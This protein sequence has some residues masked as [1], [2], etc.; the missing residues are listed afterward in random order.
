M[1]VTD[2][3]VPVAALAD[4]FEFMRWYDDAKLHGF[5]VLITDDK[6][7]VSGNIYDPAMKHNGFSAVGSQEVALTA[8]TPQHIAGKITMPK[9]EFFGDTYAYA[10]T[11]DVP[12]AAVVPPKEELKG[13]PLPAGGGEPAKAYAAYSKAIASGDLAALKKLV[14]KERASQMDSKEFKEMFGL[15][16][17][18]QPKNVKVTG[19]SVDGETAT[20][21]ATAKEG[22]DTSNGTITMVR[23][24][25]AWKVQKDSWKTTSK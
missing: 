10:A 21:L 25:G 8:M 11:F 19:G 7:V 23:E 6:R 3:E 18:M 4:E 5:R 13:T 9:G 20:L 2:Q 22:N 1:L 15:I 16:Q 14:S 24:G 17:A 12:V